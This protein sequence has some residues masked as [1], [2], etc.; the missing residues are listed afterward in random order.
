MYQDSEGTSP[1]HAAVSL[2]SAEAGS[3]L[4]QTLLEGI[5]DPA[6][7][8][9][10]RDGRMRS[11]LLLAAERGNAGPFLCLWELS[12][13]Q[14][15][16]EAADCFGRTALHWWCKHGNTACVAAILGEAKGQWSI[17]NAGTTS[18]ETPLVWALE[19]QQEA[20][21]KLLLGAGAEAKAASLMLP[22]V[23]EGSAVQERLQALIEA[24]LQEQKQKDVEE[25]EA[26]P[27]PAAPAATAVAAAVPAPS[28]SAASA[29]SLMAFAGRGR[30][31]APPAAPPAAKKLKIKLKK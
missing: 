20:I 7:L 21:V 27:T 22:P 10:L 26:A 24:R 17:V 4:A 25:E 6:A 23:G 31:V 28:S 8:L 9:G 11:P 1:L 30:G 3:A 12:R 15:Q 13:G 14:G 19:A 16:K 5:A 18:G 2:D 29:S